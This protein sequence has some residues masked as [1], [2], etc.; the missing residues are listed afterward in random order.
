M[1][2]T[3]L[4]RGVRNHYGAQNTEHAHLMT[5][6]PG[7]SIV[8]RQGTIKRSLD[9]CLAPCTQNDLHS[10]QCCRIKSRL[11]YHHASQ[12][13]AWIVLVALPPAAVH[14]EVLDVLRQNYEHLNFRAYRCRPA[15]CLRSKPGSAADRSASASSASMKWWDTSHPA[16][17]RPAN[18]RGLIVAFV[19]A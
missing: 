8:S 17:L 18:W 11:V 14:H 2:A 10:T 5:V 7:G 4:A 3:Q 9:R 1:K 13:M 12:A 16:E 6:W 19:R 15:G